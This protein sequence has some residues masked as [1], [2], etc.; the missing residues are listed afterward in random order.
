[1]QSDPTPCHQCSMLPYIE[2]IVG[3]QIVLINQYETYIFLLQI[4]LN[5]NDV[6]LSTTWK[7]RC[8]HQCLRIYRPEMKDDSVP[9][10]TL[11][12]EVC[13]L[14][15]FK[16]WKYNWHL[17]IHRLSKFCQFCHN[18]SVWWKYPLPCAFSM[19]LSRNK[20]AGKF[21]Q[22]LLREFDSRLVI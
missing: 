13:L 19:L 9:E 15:Y 21:L 10:A 6:E 4:V 16:K 14:D 11:T 3:Q 2:V 18:V 8:R 1:M 7:D 17:G 22:E 12:L 5:F 20:K